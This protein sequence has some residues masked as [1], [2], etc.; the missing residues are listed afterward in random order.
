MNAT[1]LIQGRI[2]DECLEKN[3]KNR[4]G[5][6]VFVSTWEGNNL[7]DCCKHATVL[8][9]RPPDKAGLQNFMLQLVSTIEGLKRITTSH[10][11]K[12]RGDEF[13]GYSSL[14]EKMKND[15]DLI[16]TASIFFRSF[17]VI[18]YHI[19]DHLI[20]GRTDYLLKMFESA[21]LRYEST[22]HDSDSKEWGLTKAHMRNMGFDNFEN[23]DLGKEEM[24]KMF[25]I[26]RMDELKPYRVTANCFGLISY[27]SFN[28]KDHNSIETMED[29]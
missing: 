10:V 2:E 22:M 3:I 11:I 13:F 27:D 5:L 9:N 29:L 6:P 28:P 18:P 26:I 8:K 21:K 20:A 7:I 15:P 12:V 19:S 14:L 1:I 25:N 16:F 4:C 23:Y 17:S 24:R